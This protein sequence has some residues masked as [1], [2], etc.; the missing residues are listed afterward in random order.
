LLGWGLFWAAV[1]LV[2]VVLMI[3]GSKVGKLHLRDRLIS[4][5]SW[6]GDE[7]IL[8]VGCGRG[9]LLIGA[10]KKLT[11]GKAVGVDIWQDKDLSGNRP[12]A[13]LE[14]ARAEEVIDRVELKEGRAQALPFADEGFDIVLSLS[15]LHNISREDERD[16][17]VREIVRVLRPGGRVVIH[18][19]MHTRKYAAVLR[20]QGMEEVTVSPPI[21]LWCLL[22]RTVRATKPPSIRR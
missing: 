11:R 15:T 18:D 10:A 4:A 16:Q 22:T 5:L 21:F 20:E 9:L 19:I 2:Q 13:V 3:W 6:R 17:A 1:L 14:N 12:E 8:D 7:R